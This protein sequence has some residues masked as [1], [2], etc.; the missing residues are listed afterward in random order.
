MITRGGALVGSVR[1]QRSLSVVLPGLPCE[2]LWTTFNKF[3]PLLEDVASFH[4]N[5]V[6]FSEA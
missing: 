3:S 6:S 5:L 1:G 4:Q 2:I